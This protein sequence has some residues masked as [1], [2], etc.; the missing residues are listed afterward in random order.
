MYHEG[1]KSLEQKVDSVSEQVARVSQVRANC[2]EY[3]L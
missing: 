2:N 1:F 3:G